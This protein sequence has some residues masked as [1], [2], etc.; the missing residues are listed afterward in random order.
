VRTKDFGSSNG[1]EDEALSEKPL[2]IYVA[3]PYSGSTKTKVE[4]NVATAIKVGV[5]VIRKGHYPYIP[6]LTHFVDGVEGKSL[7]LL[8]EDHLDWGLSWLDRSDAL[9]Y[10]GASRGAN[11]ELEYALKRG[12]AIFRSIEEVPS[13]GSRRYYVGQLKVNDPEAK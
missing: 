6:H 7:T 8:W 10:I 12:K 5:E 9:L 13:L 2:H 3:G 4:Q 11:I 1:F